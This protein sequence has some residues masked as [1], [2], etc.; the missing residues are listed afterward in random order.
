[1]TLSTLQKKLNDLGFETVL[2][3]NALQAARETGNE[4][5]EITID[6]G[7]GCLVI[8]KQ[9]MK[10]KSGKLKFKGNEVTVFN[11]KLS[12]RIFRVQLES[13]NDFAQV[14]VIFRKIGTGAYNWGSG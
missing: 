14:S 1:M 10:T 5:V 13:E 6:S 7:G 8:Q 11:E 2:A 4:A 12:T 9:K 3:D